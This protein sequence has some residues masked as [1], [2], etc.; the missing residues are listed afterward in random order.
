MADCRRR[1][2]E[3]R[4]K[5]VR[6]GLDDKALTSWNALMIAAFAQAAQVLDR[7]QYAAV[8]A[9]AAEFV[10]AHMRGEDGRLLRTWSRGSPAKLNAYLEDYAY[11]IDALVT[12]YE[13]TFEGRWLSDALELAGVMVEQFWDEAE[14]GFWFTGRD[15][16]ELIARHKD[17]Q[18]NATPS[19]NAMAATGLLRLAALTGRADLRDRAGRVLRL[20][21]GL[22]E[23]HPLAAG[24]SLVALDFWLGPVQEV[25]VVGDLADEET[26]RVLRAVR[27]RYAPNQVTAFRQ[28]GAGEE[29]M[30]DVPLLAGKAGGGA[31]TLYLCENFACRAPAVGAAAAL[32]ALGP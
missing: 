8:A 16:E 27:G 31:V 10:L 21:Q 20:C 26:R 24:Q 11:L 17:V 13:A 29:A 6:P 14:G 2:F 19:G 18:D 30:A 4:S 15:H 5:R 28:A 32:A 22:M 9:R 23:A 12:L 1:L 7:P 3:A 25:A